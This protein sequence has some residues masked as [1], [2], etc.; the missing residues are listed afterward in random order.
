MR[1]LTSV[2]AKKQ[3]ETTMQNL[4]GHPKIPLFLDVEC[5]GIKYEEV[6]DL[7]REFESFGINVIGVYTGFYFWAGLTGID[8]N[9][10]KN[11]AK[12]WGDLGV[13]WFSHYGMNQPGNFIQNYPGDDS[14]RWD[15]RCSSKSIDILQYSSNSV[16]PPNGGRVD[17]NAFRGSYEEL[18]K[19][20]KIG[21]DKMVCEK[22]L[23]VDPR[24]IS[25]DTYYNCGP[26]ATQTL[27]YAATGRLIQESIL[28]RELG[29]TVNGTNWWPSPYKPVLDKY[30]PGADYRVISCQN[31]LTNEEEVQMWKR[32]ANSIDAG[33][34]GIVDIW[35]PPNNRPIA[36]FPSTQSPNYGS[37][38]IMHYLCVNGYRDDGTLKLHIVDSGFNVKEYWL[39]IHNLAT[40]MVPRGY[41]YSETKPKEAPK[42]KVPSWINPQ[43]SFNEE[44]ALAN[45][46]AQNWETN[47]MVKKIFD[48][49]FAEDKLDHSKF[50]AAEIEADRKI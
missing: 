27:I 41:I 2:S 20:L 10:S 23:P 43:K 25:Q 36:V 8:P 48:K 18:R 15:R 9:D 47:R 19:L 1:P 11:T 50:L 32:L 14:S 31:Y 12:D 45:I 3:V 35:S 26:A 13:L 24:Y 17:V 22:V 5:N 30:V 29:T 44:I 28:A 16:V 38:T 40:L 7:K 46:D 34:P 21:E 37:G 49:V 6:F 33:F 4:S 39:T 42:M